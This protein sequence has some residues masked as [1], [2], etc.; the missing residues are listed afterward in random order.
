MRQ[1]GTSG[2]TIRLIDFNSLVRHLNSLPDGVERDDVAPA[3]CARIR[4][5]PMILQRLQRAV[6]YRCN[7]GN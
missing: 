4:W 7:S 5:R 1:T 2:R 3:L 6:I